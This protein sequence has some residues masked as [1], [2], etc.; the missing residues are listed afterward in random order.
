MG[1]PYHHAAST[2]RRFGGAPVEY[3][4]VHDWF[5]ATKAA[6]GFWR[7][8]ALRHHSF[9]I[10]EAER[11]FGPTLTNSVGRAVPIRVI[12]EQHVR[13]DLGWIPTVK[14]WLDGLPAKPWMVRGVA[15]AD[16][17]DVP[18]DDGGSWV[19]LTAADVAALRQIAAAYNEQASAP[20]YVPD[21]VLAPI[22][23]RDGGALLRLLRRL[24]G[25]EA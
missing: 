21:A 12:G 4:H 25:Q 5:D 15:K 9:G 3:L 7:H 23:S 13:E 24:D 14:D 2:A 11:V 20:E 10:F 16:Q 1:H 8:R 18:V 19:R 22:T 6:Y 17:D